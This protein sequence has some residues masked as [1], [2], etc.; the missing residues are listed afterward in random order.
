MNEDEELLLRWRSGDRSAGEALFER[1]FEALAR[2]FRN[3]VSDGVEDLVQQ[4][5]VGC[6]EG[7]ERLRSAAS[8]RSFLFA[9]AHNLLRTSFRAQRRGITPLNPEVDSAR[10]ASPG[11]S[12]L[13]AQHREQRLLLEGLRTVPLDAQVLLELFYWEQLTSA[14]IAEVMGVPHGTIRSRLRRARELL[15]E[16]LRALAESTELLD[17]TLQDLEG[18]AA[19]LRAQAARPA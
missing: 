19:S 14:E 11:P 9:I 2:F 16:R 3:K 1:Y 8:F 7:V 13:L 4:T 17:S 10:D 12:T 5:F 15:R 18:W 6:V